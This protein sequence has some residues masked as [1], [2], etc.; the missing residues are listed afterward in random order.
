[1]IFSSI[2]MNN[3]R[4]DRTYTAFDHLFINATFGQISS[5]AEPTMKDHILGSNEYLT[6]AQETIQQLLEKYGTGPLHP[7]EDNRP[8]MDHKGNHFVAVHN[9]HNGR[10]TLPTCLQPHHQRTTGHTQ[11][12][13]KR[14]SHQTN[15]Q[16]PEN[17]PTT[18]PAQKSAEKSLPSRR[19][20][21]H[22]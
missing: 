9:I 13:L 10:T 7:V 5:K 14:K 20:T 21:K 19:Q 2:S 6:R 15:E 22:Q 1:M 12:N 16:S 18:P 17:L 4:F 11:Q 3:L 8:D